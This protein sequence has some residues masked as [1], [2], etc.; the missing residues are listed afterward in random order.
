MENLRSNLSKQ[1]YEAFRESIG[2][3]FKAKLIGWL[4]AFENPALTVQQ[5]ITRIKQYPFIPHGFI[6][7]GLVYNLTDGHVEVVVNGYEPT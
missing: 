1:H 6:I 3:P 2:E 5:E 7:H 4:K